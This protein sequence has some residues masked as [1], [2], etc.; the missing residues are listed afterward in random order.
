MSIKD[1]SKFVAEEEILYDGASE[2]ATE[3][4]AEEA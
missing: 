2:E 1:I 3:E 4:V